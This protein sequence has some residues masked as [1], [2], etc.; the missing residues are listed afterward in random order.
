MSLVAIPTP[1]S[2][3]AAL[4]TGP[5]L[6]IRPERDWRAG[7]ATGRGRTTMRML[8]T[9]TVT[10]LMLPERSVGAPM[11]LPKVYL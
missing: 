3:R 4:P 5:P 6:D 9:A 7:T 11:G 8:T 1:S 2:H 10:G